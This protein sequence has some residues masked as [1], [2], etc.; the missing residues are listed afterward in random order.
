MKI[1][2]GVQGTGNG[3][4]TRARVMAKELYSA[5]IDVT[6]Q[7]TGRLANKYFDMEIFK[8]T[9]PHYGVLYPLQTFSKKK[10]ANFTNIPLLI[11]ANTPE[12]LKRLRQLAELLSQN[13]KEFSSEQRKWMH[14]AA[15]FACNFSNFM[16][17]A[18]EDLLKTKEMDFSL[19]H[20]LIKETAK[21]ATTHSPKIL[22]SGPAIREDRPVLETHLEMLNINKNL[23]ELY[24]NTTNAIIIDKH[25]K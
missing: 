11:E 12:N 23:R 1:F 7:F 15:V 18:A 10:R 13:V 14:L 2:Y 16:Y 22:Q 3:H 5:G 8:D 24:R 9:F 4:I 25:K 17:A 20:P 19:L 6:F 21:N